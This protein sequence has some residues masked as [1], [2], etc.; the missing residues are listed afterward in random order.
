MSGGSTQSVSG[1]GTIYSLTKDGTEK[2]LFAFN[3]GDGEFPYSGLTAA[4]GRFYG[5]TLIGGSS[6][7][8]VIYRIGKNGD[9][10]RVLHDFS[11]NDTAGY[12]PFNGLQLISGQLYGTT[13][14]GGSGGHGTLFS[15][16]LQG[17]PLSILH[18]FSGS[19]DGGGPV[20]IVP[21]DGSF[22]GTAGNGGTQDAGTAFS[23]SSE[24]L[25]LH[26]R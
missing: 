12:T 22:Y 1:A 23:I 25:S 15:M 6:N 24:Q 8:G 14:A 26:G 11:T 2:V 21:L 3:D 13:A 19:S 10:Q 20:G 16:G 9:H 4:N 17:G 5:T 18:P 7:D